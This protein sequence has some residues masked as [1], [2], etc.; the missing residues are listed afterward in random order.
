MTPVKQCISDLKGLIHT[1]TYKDLDSMCKSCTNSSQ[2]K[3]WQQE[4]EVDT[5]SHSDK[6]YLIFPGKESLN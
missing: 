4:G 3:F 6:S 5:T 2:I 1:Q